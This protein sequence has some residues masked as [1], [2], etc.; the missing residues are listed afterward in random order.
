MKRKYLIASLLAL[1]SALIG[2]PYAA[3]KRT[4]LNRAIGMPEIRLRRSALPAH[5]L[6]FPNITKSGTLWDAGIDATEYS[7]QDR[8]R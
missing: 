4:K 5:P 1:G 8:P 6:P 7:I 2:D 3:G